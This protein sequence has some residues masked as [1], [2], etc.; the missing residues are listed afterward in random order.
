MEKE[1][2]ERNGEKKNRS[3]RDL[4]KGEQQQWEGNGRRRG[5]D[6][7][8]IKKD[9]SEEEKYNEEES[10]NQNEKKPQ[11]NARITISLERED[12]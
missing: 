1:R 8:I 4:E 11:K 10:C 12:L 3:G 9:R 5:G 6:S 7:S 2:K